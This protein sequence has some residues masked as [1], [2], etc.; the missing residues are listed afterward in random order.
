MLDPTDHP[1]SLSGLVSG[2]EERKASSDLEVALLQLQSLVNR[3]DHALQLFDYAG[4]QSQ[5]V[6]D[7]ARSTPLKNIGPPGRGFADWQSSIRRFGDWRSIAA[8]DATMTIYHFKYALEEIN[9]YPPK[10]PTIFAKTPRARLKA[11]NK[12]FKDGIRN[13]VKIRDAS[14]H[15]YEFSRPRER[16]THAVN[17]GRLYIGDTI[18]DHGLEA[19]VEGKLLKAELSKAKLEILQE[20]KGHL[21]LAFHEAA[22]AIRRPTF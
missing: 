5:R 6:F 7:Y 21:F 2:Q 14:A 8:N 15:R 19:T 18:T 12:L 4:G 9:G 20:I 17:A 22:A 16:K 3:Y 13:L 11:A 1:P 10:C